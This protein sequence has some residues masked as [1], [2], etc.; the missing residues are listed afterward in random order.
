MSFSKAAFSTLAVVVLSGCATPFN[1]AP[2]ATNFPTTKQQKLQTAAHWNVIGK[3]VAER[4]I[5]TMPSDRLGNLSVTASEK[6]PFNHAVLNQIISTLVSQGKSVAKDDSSSTFKVHIETQVVA[7]NA[8]R[9]A[10]TMNGV[11][12][13]LAAGLWGVGSFLTMDASSAAELTHRS[14]GTVVGLAGATDA[15]TWFRSEYASGDIPKTEIIVTA[16][17]SDSTR[18]LARSTSTYYVNEVDAAL[19]LP[20]RSNEP[21]PAPVTVFKVKGD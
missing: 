21:K 16:S 7:F 13:L 4:L 15:Y 19:Y 11:P 1:E 18:Y 17:V 8:P 10:Y 5:A 6:S 9:T 20:T 3:D 14:A 12:T 2:I